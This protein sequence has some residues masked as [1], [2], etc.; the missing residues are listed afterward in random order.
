MCD[1]ARLSLETIRPT[2]IAK[3]IALESSVPES[4]CVVLGD[5]AR[6]QQVIWNLLSNAIK[7]TPAH[8]SVRLSVRMSET[9]VT[10]EV[11]DTGIGI[12]AEFLPRLFERF[13]QADSTSTRV[14]GGLGLGLAL[15]RHIVEIHGGQIHAMSP[16]EAM[17]STFVVQLPVRP[18]T[19]LILDAAR[20]RETY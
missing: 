12:P 2:A 3:G 17:G 6:L 5:P 1:V 7:F 4:E 10:I 9:L 8:G 15:A 20:E 14:Q 11:T 19:D 18:P 16:G 13:W